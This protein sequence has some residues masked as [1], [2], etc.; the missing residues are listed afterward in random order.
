[1]TRVRLGVRPGRPSDRVLLAVPVTDAFAAPATA[2]GTDA[3]IGAEVTE[4]LRKA[5]DFRGEPG[6]VLRVVTSVDGAPR[7][8]LAV[9]VGAVP[10]TADALRT[11]AMAVGRAATDYRTVE[12]TLAQLGA[13]PAAA[14]RAVA[15]GFLAGTYRYQPLSDRG[16]ASDPPDL[17]LLLPAATSRRTDVRRALEL[18]RVSGEAIAWV[19]RLVDAPAGDLTPPVLAQAIRERAQHSGVRARVWTSQTLRARGFGGTLGV[20]SASANPPVVVELTMGPGRPR[21]GLAGK[22]ITFDSG[23]LNLKRD[24]TE[25][26][27]MKS[28]MAAAASVAAAVCAAGSLGVDVGVRAVLPLAENMVGKGSIRPGDVVEHP[29]GRRT[30]VLDTDSEGRLVLA[31]A[32]A[33][34]TRAGVEEVVDVGTLTDGGGLG[35]L[36]WG[37]WGNDRALVDALVAAGQSSG[38]PGWA[39]PLRPE[40][41]RLI[42][43]DVADIV[44]V[45]WDVPDTAV[46]AATYLSTFADGVRWAHI[47]NGSTA[48]LESA[49]EPWPRGGTGSPTRA[50]L[51]FLLSRASG[52]GS[53]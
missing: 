50:L 23:G 29:D 14:V 41:R 13:D 42:G 39:L 17:S 3:G 28:D 5:P 30:E 49:L 24:G 38:D 16:G 36:M 4:L 27:W 26:R 15:D 31:D 53:A 2:P 11:A 35:H 12:T 34:L 10:P 47:D 46:L 37:C 7:H 8:V 33:Y 21:V 9:G 45:A 6:E 25:I 1:M 48:Y 18:A 40:Y 51:E 32:I 19:R 52:G 43:S 20:G 44:N 22:G